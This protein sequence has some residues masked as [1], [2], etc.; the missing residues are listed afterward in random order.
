MMKV[1]SEYIILIYATTITYVWSGERPIVYNT[2][3]VDI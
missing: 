3:W 2:E 1:S